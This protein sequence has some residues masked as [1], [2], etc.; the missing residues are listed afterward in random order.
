MIF[1][2]MGS[3]ASVMPLIMVWELMSLACSWLRLL[4]LAICL[5]LSMIGAGICALII[6]YFCVRLTGIYF[7]ILTM[8]FGQLIYYIIFKWYSFTRGDDGLQGIIAPDLL[9]SANAY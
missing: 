4:S 3:S 7:A 2:Y 1:G 6:G 8:A 9:F 5:P